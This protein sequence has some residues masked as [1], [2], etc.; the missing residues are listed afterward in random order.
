VQSTCNTIAAP[1]EMLPRHLVTLA[2]GGILKKFK[3]VAFAKKAMKNCS[4]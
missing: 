4:I 3:K 2:K 1:L